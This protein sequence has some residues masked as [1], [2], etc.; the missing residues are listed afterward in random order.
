MDGECGDGAEKKPSSREQMV[1]ELM[2]VMDG[3]C[4]NGAGKKHRSG[5]KMVGELMD[6]R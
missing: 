2:E 5:S 1:D 4:G 3:E 6:W